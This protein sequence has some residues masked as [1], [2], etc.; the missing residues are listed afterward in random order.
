MLPDARTWHRPMSWKAAAPPGVAGQR[1][2][3]DDEQRGAVVAPDR[4]G[5]VLV[6]LDSL[7]S[8]ALGRGVVL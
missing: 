4:T 7:G 1:L 3:R 6:Q 5:E 8:F 2:L